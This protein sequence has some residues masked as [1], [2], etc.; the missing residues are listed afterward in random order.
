KSRPLVA[1]TKPKVVA[2]DLSGVFDLE[3]TALKMLT[4]A[5]ERQR[6]TGVLL[7]LVG[8]SPGVLAMVQRSPLGETLGRERMCFNLEQ[9]VA[10]YLASSSEV[11]TRCTRSAASG[12]AARPLARR[13][14]ILQDT[15]RDAGYPADDRRGGT[16]EDPDP[17]SRPVGGRPCGLL[18]EEAGFG[19][20][21]AAGRAGR[22]GRSPGPVRDAR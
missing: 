6:A 4:E 13:G 16:H 12:S 21:A 20:G 7:W 19:A 1:E 17:R 15:E 5:E 3:Y 2:L 9:A 14:T 11:T 18:C 10:R 8:L 22:H